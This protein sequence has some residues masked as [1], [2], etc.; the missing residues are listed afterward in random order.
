MLSESILS[1]SRPVTD[2]EAQVEQLPELQPEQE[3]PP[4]P[5]TLWGTPLTLVEKAAKVDILRRAGLWHLGHSA[6]S[7]AWLNG[8]IFSNFELHPEQ[9]YS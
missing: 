7:P 5:G 2:Y 8:R 1:H 3:L 4:A 9:I 6:P